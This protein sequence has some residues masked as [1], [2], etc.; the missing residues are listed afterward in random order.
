MENMFAEEMNRPVPKSLDECVVRGDTEK[1]L[2]RWAVLIETIGGILSAIILGGGVIL[3][4]I[5][6]GAEIEALGSPYEQAIKDSLGSFIITCIVG[7]IS[8]F[9]TY[10]ICHLVAL[11][12]RAQASI[13]ENTRIS[14]DI[15]MYKAA[16]EEEQKIEQ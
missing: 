6:M 9:I 10:L 7:V 15:A 11:S 8:A 14:A 1:E 3:G 5:I 13:V 12:V 2:W 16:Q 4:L